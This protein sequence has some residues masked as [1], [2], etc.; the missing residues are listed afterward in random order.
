MQ[1]QLLSR[2]QMENK[3]FKKIV[4]VTL[5]VILVG[6][7]GY[8]TFNQKNSTPTPEP[9][10]ENKII[11]TALGQQF[12]LKKG[13]IAKIGDTGLEVEIT[14][15]YNS[16]CPEGAQC[17]WSGVGIA[18]EYRFSGQVQK[19]I[20]LVQAFGYQTTIVKTDHET[21]ADLTVENMK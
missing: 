13:Q 16:P 15:F 3:R 12:N 9:G 6:V 2:A 14:E 11:S 19:G 7:V 10:P 1:V 4:F 21:Y 5:V 20:D 18:L 17:I 8:F